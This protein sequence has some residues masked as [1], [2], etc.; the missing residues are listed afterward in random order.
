M[1]LQN[2]RQISDVKVMLKVGA[3]GAGIADIEKTGT[4]GLVDTY[5][6]T[7]DDGRKK[8]FTVTNGNG[9]ASIALTGTQDLVDTYTITFDNGDTET[10]EVTNGNYIEDIEKTSSVGL[11]DTYTIHM[12]DGTAYTFTVTNGS[13]ATGSNIVV[14]TSDAELIGRNVSISQDGVVLQTLQFDSSGY[15]NFRGIEAT[16]TLDISSS[17]SGGATVTK[18]ISVPY[19]GN[20]ETTIALFRA[21]I[22]LTAPSVASVSCE[23]NNEAYYG[24]GS[25]TFTVHSAGTFTLGAT[26]DGQR[27]TT[28]VTITTDGQS[29][30]AT[31]AFG[32]INVTLESG[33]V[34]SNI[35]CTDGTTT[36]AKTSSTT[37]LTFYPPNTGTWTI[38]GSI[39]G[40]ASQVQATVSSLSTP[41][42]VTLVSALTVTV[43]LH[44]AS[45][46]TISYTDMNGAK[47]QTL[48]SQG[49]KTGVNI[50]VRTE[51]TQITFTDTNVAPNVPNLT[52]HY[53]KTVTIS[54]GMSDIYVMPDGVVYWYGNTEN[55][56]NLNG[57]SD[58]NWYGGFRATDQIEF[59]TNSVTITSNNIGGSQDGGGI[60][61]INLVYGAKMKYIYTTL[62]PNSKH[63]IPYAYFS[64]STPV[65][66][67]TGATIS[68]AVQGNQTYYEETALNS[69]ALTKGAYPSFFIQPDTVDRIILHALWA[70]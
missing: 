58:W 63:G 7:L 46:A 61:A 57:A 37:S 69:Y 32:T 11:V 39:G 68:T 15:A 23:G 25:T 13:N 55:C 27:K 36:I 62:G 17:A 4:S 41:V 2:S 38:I 12:V 1:S 48:N 9:I 22:A 44:G 45:N 56:V 5:T 16:G 31:I 59:N 6:I 19:F 52:G 10:F 54:A 70:E 20:Y 47:T 35:T 30:S 8:T 28:T 53:S 33:F 18:Q 24:T 3:D 40:V 42:S 60:G 43:T 49:R 66:F 21:T 64:Y 50:T 34:G 14:S 29:A 67:Y 51:G 65:K 26:I